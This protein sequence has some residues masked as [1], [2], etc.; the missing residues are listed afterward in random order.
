MVSAARL[1]VSVDPLEC[2]PDREP[3]VAVGGEPHDVA[4]GIIEHDGQRKARARP[5]GNGEDFGPHLERRVGGPLRL[6]ARPAAFLGRRGGPLAADF[7]PFDRA[8]LVK[9][10]LVGLAAGGTLGPGPSQGGAPDGWRQLGVAHG[11]RLAE[12]RPRQATRPAVHLRVTG[13]T[14]ARSDPYRQSATT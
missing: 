14:T 7:T 1:S 13:R 5:I 4:G 3:R 12:G 10:M 8:V 6:L 11:F 9:H 2:A